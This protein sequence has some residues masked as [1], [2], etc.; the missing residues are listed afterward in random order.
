LQVHG[1]HV[2]SREIVVQ[3]GRSGDLQRVRS[4]PA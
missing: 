1:V 2:C 4:D 3:V